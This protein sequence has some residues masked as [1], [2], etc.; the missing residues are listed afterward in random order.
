MLVAALQ[1]A[2]LALQCGQAWTAAALTF[3]QWWQ[4]SQE[5]SQVI[6][7]SAGAEAHLFKPPFCEQAQAWKQVL[8]IW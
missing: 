5:Y 8:G 6:A 4:D 3:V 7:A 1:L 2:A